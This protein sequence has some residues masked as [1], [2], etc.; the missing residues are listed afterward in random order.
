[1]EQLLKL[2][3]DDLASFLRTKAKKIADFQQQQDL[4]KF[5]KN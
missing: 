3:A 1:M 5:G 2:Q 4:R